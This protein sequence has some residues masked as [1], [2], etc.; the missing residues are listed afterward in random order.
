MMNYFNKL[1]EVAEKK[2]QQPSNK[3]VKIEGTFKFKHI[4]IDI[5]LSS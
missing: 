2:L 1:F 5:N 4:G 3:N